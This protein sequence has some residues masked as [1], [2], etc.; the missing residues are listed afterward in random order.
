MDKDKIITK[1]QKCLRLSESGNANEAASALRQARGLMSKYGIREE[2]I[3]NKEVAEAEANSGGY[4]NPPYW[5]VALSELIAQAFD[6][7]AFI[8]RKEEHRAQFRFIGCGVN[9]TV[10][11]Y[12]FTVLYRQLRRAR[13]EY[14]KTLEIEDKHERVRQ[15]NVFAQA[16]LFSVARTVAEFAGDAESHELID[17]YVNEKYGKTMEFAREHT[18]PED[19]DYDVILSGMRAA[20]AVRLFRPVDAP[21]EQEQLIEACA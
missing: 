1:I 13:R 9:A 19:K 6:S 20:D 21:D 8:S 16:W 15:G 11:A 10:C 14:M 7:K 3:L 12:A 5:A 18:S 4:Y 17:D 2:E